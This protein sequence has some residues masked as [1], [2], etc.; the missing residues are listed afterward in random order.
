[1][2]AAA[3]LRVV[4]VGAGAMGRQW[5]KAVE[6]NPDV[7]LV[8]L[9]DLDV[10]AARAA[11]GDRADG[12]VAVGDDLD[13][14][15]RATAADA[16]VN[17]TVPPAHLPVSSTALLAGCHVLC[18][19][20]AAPTVADA[21][22][23]AARAAVS[24]K[25]VMISQSRR[26]LPELTT[27]R[28]VAGSLAPIGVV[29][30]EFFKA[31][32]FGGFREEMDH[33]LLVD[34]A[35]HSFDA[36]RYLLG[37]EPVAVFCEEFNPP[38]SWYQGAANTVAVFEFE[39]GIRYVYTGSWCAEGLE[40][41]WNGE[42]RVSGAGGSAEWDGDAAVRAGRP[43]EPAGSA[44]EVTVDEPREIDGSLAEFVR[45]VRTGT[46]PASEVHA[47]ITSLAMVEAAVRSAETGERVSIASVL[48]DAQAAALAA[49]PHDAVRREISSGSVARLCAAAAERSRA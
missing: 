13:H 6:A 49:E 45:S 41:S 37:A 8:G 32:R 2:T 47:N 1:M 9:V 20:P 48:A 39:G 31:P 10:A 26:Y 15:L 24:G 21:L 33:V 11:V 28:E 35:I 42:W 5:L 44:V 30:T 17:V 4:Q 40:T 43:G 3:P 38:Y 25:L 29:T 36:A 16:V 22:R 34:M 12:A 23:L 18:E 7:E 27:L 14:I 46:V 19:K